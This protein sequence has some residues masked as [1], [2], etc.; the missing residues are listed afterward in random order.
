MT[1]VLIVCVVTVGALAI[2]GWVVNVAQSAPNLDTLKPYAPGSPSQ[3]FAANGTSLGYIWSPTVHTE[4]AG[5]SIPQRL[6]EATIAIEDRRFYQHGAL[7]YQGIVRAAIKDAVKGGNGLQ[8]AST[9]TMQL[10]DNTYLPNRY[11]NKHDLKYKIVQAKLAEQ[12]E[13]E[14]SKNW[15]LNSY[16]ND[17]P[18]GTVGGQTAYGVAAA[19]QMFFDTPVQKLS[20]PQVALLA[21]L[22]QA[23]SE[24]NPFLH[25]AAA[26][27]RRSEVLGAMV[28]AGY[29]TQGQADHAAGRSLQIKADNTLQT[30]KDPYLFDF[31]AQQAAQD[32]CPRT[33]KNCK[34]LEQGGLKIYST[35]DLHK[36]ALAQQ[37]IVANEPNLAAQGGPGVAAALASVNT[38]NGNILAVANSSSYSQTRFS[39]ATQAH[40]QTGSAFKVFAL[41]TL[42]HDYHGDPNSTYYTS[43]PLPVGWLPLAPAWSVHTDTNTYNGTIN[44][45]KA[46]YISDNTVFAQLVAD[47]GMDKFNATAHAMGITSPLDDNPAE[48]LGGLTVGVTPLEMADAYATLAN[49]GNHVPATVIGRVVFPDGSVRNFGN[50]R[51]TPVFPY[52]EAYAGTSVLKQV[53]TTAGATG[54]AANYGCPAAGKTGTAENL[55]NAWFV[56]YTPRMSTAVWVG[57]PSGNVPMINGFGGVLAAPIWRDYMHPASGDYCGNWNPPTTTFDGT[58]FFG[59]HAATGSSSTIPSNPSSQ[60]APGTTTGTGTTPSGGTG[61]GTGT[62][63]NGYNNPTLYAHPPQ[64]GSGTTGSPPTPPG[65]N[66][67]GGAGGNGAGGNGPKKH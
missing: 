13:G 63:T 43:K 18:Y 30:H 46:T 66:G 11:K 28:T 12:L 3:V 40:R 14:H 65:T 60:T 47:E 34:T 44:L 20:L 36:Q 6:K 39:Y 16:L 4:I 29:I 50:P 42:I 32:L 58:A 41:M 31:I 15:I 5:S 64:S 53:I 22:P 33:P 48:V 26:L 8:G 51:H 19:S 35:I 67:G 17:V 52:D 27:R 49:G 62:S 10:V 7:D 2:A 23:P 57:N 45:T 59:P 1:A 54:T 38:S 9:L 24:Y 55:A 61:V 37:A 21:G 56:G 25:R